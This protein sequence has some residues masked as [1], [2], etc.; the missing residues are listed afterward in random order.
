VRQK[1]AYIYTILGYD[2]INDP[3]FIKSHYH[4]QQTRDYG[5]KDKILSRICS[6]PAGIPMDKIIPSLG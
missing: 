3:L 4:R 5:F 2:V 1:I 6:F